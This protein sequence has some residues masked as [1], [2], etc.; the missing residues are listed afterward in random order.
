MNKRIGKHISRL[1]SIFLV[2]ALLAGQTV[3]LAAPSRGHFTD[4]PEGSWA[5]EYV[6]KA[7]ADGAVSGVSGDA[8][9]GTGVFN[10]SKF[11]TYAEFVTIMTKAFYAESIPAAQ[12]GEPWYAPYLKTGISKKIL[13]DRKSVV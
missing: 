13:T 10:K 12:S 7:Y 5:Y 6:E 4:V 9:S 2:T 11:L 1:V 3:V 8:A